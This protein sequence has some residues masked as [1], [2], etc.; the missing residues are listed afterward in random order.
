MTCNTIATI[1]FL[2]EPV[3]IDNVNEVLGTVA[4]VVTNLDQDDEQTSDNAEI[5]ADVFVQIDNLIED[6]QLNVT[7]LVSSQI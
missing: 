5:I 3:S 1:Y 6:G 4:S 7:V 2:Q